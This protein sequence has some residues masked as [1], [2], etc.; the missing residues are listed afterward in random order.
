[1]KRIGSLVVL[2]LAL[3]L[4]LMAAGCGE[5]DTPS[6]ARVTTTEEVVTT[7]ESREEEEEESTP[8][9]AAA[10]TVEVR[11]LLDHALEEYREGKA[12]EAEEIVGDAYLEHYEK[13][14]HPLDELDHELN[15]ELEVLIS[16][17]IR[18]RMKEGADAAAVEQ[19]VD[20][21]KEKL[22]RAESLLEGS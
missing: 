9:D 16:T 2:A 20:D 15:E 14:E 22:S 12:A 21:A 6:A 19:L 13:V 7:E 11:A 10:E 3:A 4:V 17:T 8:E 5:S 18:N 1:M